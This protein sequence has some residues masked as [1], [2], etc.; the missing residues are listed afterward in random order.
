MPG[1]LGLHNYTQFHKRHQKALFVIGSILG[2]LKPASLRYTV[3][4][5]LGTEF[6][7]LSQS[8]SLLHLD[9]PKEKQNSTEVSPVTFSCTEQLQHVTLNLNNYI[10]LYFYFCLFFYQRGKTPLSWA[11]LENVDWYD[12][13]MQSTA[14]IVLSSILSINCFSREV[15]QVFLKESLDRWRSICNGKLCFQPSLISGKFKSSLIVTVHCSSSLNKKNCTQLLLISSWGND[16]TDE[17]SI[18]KHFNVII[19]FSLLYLHSVMTS[20][21]SRFTGKKMHSQ[22]HGVLLLF[23]MLSH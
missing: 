10:S 19:K 8:T 7:L 2:G 13:I 17:S 5:T 15:F 9:W 21:Y 4:A 20:L 16:S 14:Y 23:V 6:I 3:R 12:N 1:K 18:L 11:D 22:Q